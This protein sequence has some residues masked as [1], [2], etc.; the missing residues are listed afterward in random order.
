[1]RRRLT[2]QEQLLIVL[3][4]LVVLLLLVY[5]VITGATR[6]AYGDAEKSLD[7]AKKAHQDAIDLRRKYEQ[8]GR[9]I[10]VRKERISSQDT[11]FDLGSFIAEVEASFTPPFEHKGATSPSDQNFAGDK[12]TRTRITYTYEGKRLDDITNIKLV[13]DEATGTRFTMT[14]TLSVVTEN[15]TS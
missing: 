14:I 8:L 9:E 10:E 15:P 12:Y 5:G 2:Q 3:G 1:M 11:K 13:T 6:S 7:Q 4:A